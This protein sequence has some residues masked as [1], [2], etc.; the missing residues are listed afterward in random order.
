MRTSIS[1]NIYARNGQLDNAARAYRSTL[2]IDPKDTT[3]RN[4]LGVIYA[5]QGKLNQAI[6]Q[7]ERILEIEPA[8]QEVQEN[9]SKAKKMMN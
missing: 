3:A 1:R 5:R 9:I 2:E 8:N 6:S 4:N 7:W